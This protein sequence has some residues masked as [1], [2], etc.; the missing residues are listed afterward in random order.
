MR[1]RISGLADGQRVTLRAT[2]RDGQ[3]RVWASSATFTAGGSG[4]VDLAGAAP[5]AGSY[6]VADAAGPLW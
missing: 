6:R 3:D 4:V 5:V 1:I 2:T